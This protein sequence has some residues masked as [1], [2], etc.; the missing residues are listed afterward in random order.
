MRLISLLPNLP[1]P[2][3]AKEGD[4]L[5]GLLAAAVGLIEKLLMKNT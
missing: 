4:Y 1:Y 2:L 3:F 5:G